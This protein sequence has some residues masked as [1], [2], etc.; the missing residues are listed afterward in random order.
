MTVRTRPAALIPI[1]GPDRAVLDVVAFPCAGSSPGQFQGWR[2]LVPADW[3]LTAVCL[4]GRGPRTGEPF[5]KRLTE[6][7]DEAAA[8]ITAA[9]V[10]GRPLL[11]VG[12]SL[13]GLIAFETA[14]RVR[15]AALAAFACPPPH[16]LPDLPPGDVDWA[17]A[18][19][20][21]GGG[22]LPPG[23]ADE[24]IELYRPVYEADMEMLD[25]YVWDRGRAECD[26]W[27]LYSE[28]DSIPVV[29]WA[30]QTTARAEAAALPGDHY[31]ARDDPGRAV[32]E[33]VGRVAARADEWTRTT[34]GGQ[35]CTR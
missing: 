30:E 18:I 16:R 19:A 4:P 33:L 35:A 12:H 11:L 14:R 29:P 2:T 26:I 9:L 25:D 5:A 15:P 22:Q 24:L 17:A 10:P 3:R 8:A 1:T 20:P 7:A 23:L 27:A 28:A 32:R 13:G 31:L 21:P 34:E 6:A